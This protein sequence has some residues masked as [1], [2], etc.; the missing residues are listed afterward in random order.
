MR[1]EVVRIIEALGEK[2]LGEKGRFLLLNLQYSNQYYYPGAVGSYFVGL[3]LVDSE[4]HRLTD[5][6]KEVVD[7]LKSMEKMLGD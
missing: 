1:E 6:G 3:G 4:T 2:A 5:L 7:V